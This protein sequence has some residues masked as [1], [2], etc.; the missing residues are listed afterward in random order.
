MRFDGFQKRDVVV[1]ALLSIPYFLLRVMIIQG[2]MNEYFDYDEGTY[3]MIARFINQGILPYRDVF[4]VHPPLYYYLLALWLRLFGDSYIVGRSFSIVLGL[5]AAVFAYFTGKE[6]KDWRLGALFALVLIF[7]PT[8][9]E[10]NS[11][12]FHETSIELFTVLS[13]YHFVKYSKTDEAKHAYFSLFW[14]GLGTTS[15]FTMI[16]YAVALYLT[17]VL[18]LSKETRD[19]LERAAAL[20][21]NRVQ[22][23]ILTAT[24]LFLTVI[25]VDVIVSYPSDFMRSILIVPG[26]HPIEIVGQIFSVGLFLII[27]GL[28][29]LYVTKIS[30]V[31]PLL[32]TIRVVVENIKP[33]L[34]L[35]L[36]LLIPKIVVE[37]T[38]GL[39]V[40]MSYFT[41]TYLAQK[42]RYA[43]IINPFSYVNNILKHL[44]S[45]KSQDYLVFY[46][47]VMVL[48]AVLLTGWAK[49]RRF[50]LEKSLGSLLLMNF[51]MYFIVFPIVPNQRFLYPF[52][53]VFYLVVLYALLDQF[54]LENSW[55]TSLAVF[56]V[57]M[58][59]VGA[60]G[61]GMAY[62]YP[63]GDLLIAWQ[64]HGKELRDDLGRYISQH[65]IS[66][67]T[68]LAMNPF[69]AYYL[70]LKIEPWYLDTFGL[71][72]LY[73]SSQLWEAVNKSDYLIFST[74]M[75]TMEKESSVFKNSFG[76]LEKTAHSRYTLLFSKSY[77]QGDVITLIKR[78]NRS[79]ALS[80]EAY[81]GKVRVWIN[82]SSVFY[83]HVFRSPLKDDD[84]TEIKLVD[85]VYTATQ[86]VNGTELKFSI[87]PGEN[88]T[89]FHF[90]KVINVTLE[91][92]EPVVILNNQGS[93]A[94]PGG[95]GAFKVYSPEHMV[96]FIL[97][98]GDGRIVS[99]SSKE[100][101]IECRELKVL[102][103]S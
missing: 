60:S 36:A 29:F 23:F 7:D 87:S 25:I 102:Q 48:L 100:V 71:T 27:W 67:G 103:S 40:S 101:V 82:G 35:T 11:L 61:I 66:E 65:N 75:Y 88:G 49:G 76:E 55:K 56:I 18:F 86:R 69:N 99:V 2:G 78:D 85:G 93:Y 21:F 96:E 58:I 33:A 31:K 43:P 83:L 80:F 50:R 89:T 41:Q 74:W 9:V 38:L 45:D 90:P 46:I 34:E 53:M 5:I 70:H 16:P 30:Y 28:L 37:G 20:I 24:T 1:V 72:Y 32:R 47:P 42:S 95:R 63:K 52:F 10:M 54:E 97:D 39:G 44:Y 62:R 68:Y 14:A 84:F 91:F 6:L 19:Y 22:T 57:M 4:A 81:L 51:L 13:L 94:S 17:L 92:T 64:A 77:P 15:K 73:N 8:M 12:V 59:L 98:V 26:I 3:L 79:R